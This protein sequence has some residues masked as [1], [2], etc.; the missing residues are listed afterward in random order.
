MKYVKDF[1]QWTEFKKKKKAEKK[2]QLETECCIN[3]YNMF[4]YGFID[5]AYVFFGKENWF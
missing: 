1:F 3:I 2:V 4:D 5:P